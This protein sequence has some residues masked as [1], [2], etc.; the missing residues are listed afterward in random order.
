MRRGCPLIYQLSSLS[1]Y[2]AAVSTYANLCNRRRIQSVF[3]W[4]CI[5]IMP[6]S[7]NQDSMRKYW[8][9]SPRAKSAFVCTS[10]PMSTAAARRAQREGETWAIISAEEAW[11]GEKTAGSVWWRAVFPR[12]CDGSETRD[13]CKHSCRTVFATPRL[14]FQTLTLLPS[15]DAVS[16]LQFSSAGP[17]RAPKTGRSATLYTVHT[18]EKTKCDS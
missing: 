11:V 8:V 1:R 12:Q 15:F 17:G 7:M 2:T 3:S 9:Q 14:P 5:A 18:A 13:P 4:V 10:L 16:A 6:M